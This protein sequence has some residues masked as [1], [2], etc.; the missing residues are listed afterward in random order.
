MKRLGWWF[1]ARRAFWALFVLLVGT[2]AVTGAK[3][4]GPASPNAPYALKIALAGEKAKAPPAD[5]GSSSQYWNILCQ[6]EV[7]T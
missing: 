6:S 3:E 2:P 7:S 5:S 4:E 1:S